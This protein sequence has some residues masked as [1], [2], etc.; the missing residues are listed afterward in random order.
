M[1]F[2]YLLLS[3]LLC[4]VCYFF[5]I[6][7]LILLYCGMCVCSRVLSKVCIHVYI[8]MCIFFSS[9]ILL[10]IFV[11]ELCLNFS[12][13]VH[14]CWSIK[15]FNYSYSCLCRVRNFFLSYVAIKLRDYFYFMSLFYVLCCVVLVFYKRLF[16]ADVIFLYR[17]FFFCVLVYHMYIYFVYLSIC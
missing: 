13:C 16:V 10:P 5:F 11:N 9:F 2:I 17:V 6:G 15:F 12:S 14:G 1:L 4:V 3:T 8:F 7:C